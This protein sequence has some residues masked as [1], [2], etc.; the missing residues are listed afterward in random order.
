MNR[1]PPRSTRTYT[2]CPYTTLFRSTLH[3][4]CGEKAADTV[5]HD[6]GRAPDFCGHDVARGDQLIYG[7]A[8][9]TSHAA[10]VR[11][12][13]TDRFDRRPGVAGRQACSASAAVHRYVL[14]RC[15]LN[16]RSP[17]MKRSII[18]GMSLSGVSA[19]ASPVSLAWTSA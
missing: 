7:R 19:D 1:R 13:N 12:A 18:G 5:H 14:R 6:D 11:N 3:S 9:Q 10:G 8:P 15:L 17:A 2:L 16:S 4:I